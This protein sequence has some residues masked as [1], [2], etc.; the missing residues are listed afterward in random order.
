MKGVK[1]EA[2]TTDA[3]YHPGRTAKAI[4]KDGSV[5]ATLG[6]VHPLTADNYGMDMPVYVASIDFENLFALA[7][8]KSEYKPLPKF[9]ASTRDYSFVCEDEL[10]VGVIEEVMANAGGKL[11]ESI[12]LFDI[13][14]G[15]Q[16]GEGKKSVSLRVSMRAADRTLT[17]EETDKISAK[18]VKALDEKLGIA[19]RS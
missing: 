17:V 18:I 2:Y 9:P 5:L 6:Q 19:L 7:N 16:V 4:A 15:H 3:L 12:K 14:R 10:E 11:V 8:M 13:Y 1:Y